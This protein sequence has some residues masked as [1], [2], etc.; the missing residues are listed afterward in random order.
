MDPE[1]GLPW[2]ARCGAFFWLSPPACRGLWW[3]R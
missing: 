1:N 2:C 3:W